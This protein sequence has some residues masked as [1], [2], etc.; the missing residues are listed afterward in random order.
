MTYALCTTCSLQPDCRYREGRSNVFLCEEHEGVQPPPPY[1]EAHQS[2]CGP[3]SPRGE[4]TGG[5]CSNC[6]VEA[7]C[8]FPRP[9]T[10]VLNCL[11]YK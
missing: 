7:A 6:A 3:A 4:G 1:R 8:A 9:V 10:G 5:L 11:E 2:S